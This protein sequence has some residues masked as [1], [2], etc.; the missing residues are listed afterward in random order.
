[1]PTVTGPPK[2]SPLP[3]VVAILSKV[4]SEKK[5]ADDNVAGA[6]DAKL[7]K[8]MGELLTEARVGKGEVDA[9]EEK[10]GID[11][12]TDSV[13]FNSNMWCF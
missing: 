3:K 2:H 13:V 1:M 11:D 7:P 10:G 6:V 5:E 8:I 4:G 12:D 9:G